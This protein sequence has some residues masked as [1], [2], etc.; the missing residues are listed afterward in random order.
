MP[1]N[2]EI[3]Y[4]WVGIPSYGIHYKNGVITKGCTLMEVI[5]TNRLHDYKNDVA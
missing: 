1:D 2:Q 4:A 5:F 3:R